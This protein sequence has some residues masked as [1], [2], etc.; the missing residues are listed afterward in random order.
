MAYRGRGKGRGKPSNSILDELVKQT[1]R[2]VG[3]SPKPPQLKEIEGKVPE[4]FPDIELPQLHQMDD[5]SAYLL[6]KCSLIRQRFRE[7]PFFLQITRKTKDIHRYAEKYLP[8][9]QTQDL[10]SILDLSASFFPPDLSLTKGKVKR[11]K[12]KGE[13]ID[14][15]VDEAKKKL[16]PK[17]RR[18]SKVDTPIVG[19][20]PEKT[21]EKET[22]DSKL[23]EL[24]KEETTVTKKLPKEKEK[25]NEEEEPVPEEEISEDE[26]GYCWKEDEDI[27]DSPNEGGDEEG[28]F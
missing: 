20:N 26:G 4:L 17:R 22:L 23:D 12:R 18:I 2:E 28:I 8:K 14:D 27:D 13:D 21:T 5:E 1:Q 11:Q 7:S 10:L 19:N 24:E 25:E 16:I 3:I 6:G 9:V 15:L